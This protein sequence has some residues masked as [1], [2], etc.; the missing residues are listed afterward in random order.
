MD[1][2]VKKLWIKALRSNEFKQGR[3]FLEKNNQYCAL[4]VLSVLALIEGE[5]TYDKREGVGHFDNKKRS[6]SYNVCLWAGLSLDDQMV[7]LVYDGKKCNI[8][9][10][11][12][13]GL[14]LLDIA[15]II[16]ASC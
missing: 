6:L 11:N 3:G 1:N 14:S 9:Q 8:A 10:L 7:E 12:D 16:E 5:C 2:R 15:N 4:G 13:Q